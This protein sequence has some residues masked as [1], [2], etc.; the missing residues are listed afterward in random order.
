MGVDRSTVQPSSRPARRLVATLAVMAATMLA[1]VEIVRTAIFV[2]PTQAVIVGDLLP[3]FTVLIP[4]L[5]GLGVLTAWRVRHR[6]LWLVTGCLL[7]VGM[8]PFGLSPELVFVAA[9]VSVGAVSPELHQSWYEA[10]FASGLLVAVLGVGTELYSQFTGHGSVLVA[11]SGAIVFGG[12]IAAIGVRDPVQRNPLD[13]FLNR[14]QN[15]GHVKAALVSGLATERK[16]YPVWIAVVG[17]SFGVCLLHF[18]GLRYGF[19]TEFWWWDVM[20]H[21]CSGLGVGAWV[22]LLRPP[23][24]RIRRRLFVFLP[25]VV[26]LFGAGFE[27]YEYLFRGFYEPWSVEYYLRDTIEDMMYNL[28]GALLFSLLRYLSR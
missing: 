27:I 12:A 21:T 26:F 3:V 11:V 15:R 9:F 5:A 1:S 17:W 22:Y 20:T 7:L 23:A 10:L 18:S 8:A 24:F 2:A 6:E 28:T 16:W 25:A 14:S 4:P 13:T 19:Y